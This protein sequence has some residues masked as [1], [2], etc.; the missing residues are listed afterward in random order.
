M[1]LA[2]TTAVR[3]EILVE[4]A[5]RYELVMDLLSAIHDLRNGRTLDPVETKLLD[6]AS[7]A[8]LLAKLERVQQGLDVADVE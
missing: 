1:A 3:L 2:D 8:A 4:A 5:C 6:A 7:I